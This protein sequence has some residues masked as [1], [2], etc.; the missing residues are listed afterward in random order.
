MNKSAKTTAAHICAFYKTKS[1]CKN[2]KC[3]TFGHFPGT[4]SHNQPPEDQPEVGYLFKIIFTDSHYSRPNS[5]RLP[6]PGSGSNNSSKYVG[7]TGSL[8]TRM[9]LGIPKLLKCINKA[10]PERSRSHVIKNT[11]PE[12]EPCLRKQ[13]APE[14]ESIRL[15][16]SSAALVLRL[17]Q[18]RV[19]IC[20]TVRSKPVNG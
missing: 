12:P 20:D 10:Q 16:E 3:D 4:N 11:A 17:V 7:I 9:T 8:V 14:P 6:R 18:M 5:F 15:Y 13:K 1:L 19:S 2:A